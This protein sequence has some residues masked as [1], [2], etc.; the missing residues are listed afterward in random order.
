MSS[1]KA[2]ISRVNGSA[3]G[4]TVVRRALLAVLLFIATWL[5][6]R[7]VIAVLSPE[8]LFKPVQNA[9]VT[10]SG[11]SAQQQSFSFIYDPFNGPDAPLPDVP[12][13]TGSDAPETTLNLELTG[14]RAGLNGS[15]FIRTPDGN[16]DNYYID[17]ELLSGVILRGVF[18][19]YVLLEVNGQRQR[20]TTED[21]KAARQG[22][23]VSSTNAR[24]SLSTLRTV[25]AT[26]LISK[27]QIV[28][29]LDAQGNRIGVT[30]S[31]R[32]SAVSLS[33]FGLQDGDIVTGIA[34]VSLTSGLP[35]IVDLRRRIRPNRPVRV[36]IIRDGSPQTLF[37]GSSS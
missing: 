34:G 15:A 28:P 37:I 27:V 17:E 32:S 18:P 5:A 3:L 8:S 16:E 6:V 30:L 35:D 31:P 22:E 11:S 12:V 21:A 10:T 29:S 36:N 9:N 14:L 1:A 26:D 24:Q 20:L 19:D 4:M 13:D 7:L 33:D 23:D 2:I 25:D